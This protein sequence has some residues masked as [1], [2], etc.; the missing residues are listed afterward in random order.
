MELS[1]LALNQGLTFL[2][3][4]TGVIVIVVGVFLVKLLYDL[5]TLTKNVNET[6][7]LLNKEL[8]PTLY[9]LKETLEAVNSII[10]STDKGVDSLKTA[11]ENVFGKTKMLSESLFNGIMKGFVT[12][13]GLF[14]K[15][16]S[17]KQLK[18]KKNTRK[19]VN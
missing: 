12:V 10:H 6:S 18:V 8:R 14:S 15:K 9:E 2:A 7:V 11:V 16:K 19:G 4:A 3:W 17:V 5:S 13:M 1:Q